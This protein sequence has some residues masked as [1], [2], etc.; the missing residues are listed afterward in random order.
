MTKRQGRPASIARQGTL[1]LL[2]LLLT[3]PA[4]GRVVAQAAQTTD[5]PAPGTTQSSPRPQ[6]PATPATEAAPA[7]A[8]TTTAGAQ[9]TTPPPAAPAPQPQIAPPQG[10]AIAPSEKDTGVPASRPAGAVIAPGKQR[11]RRSILIRVGLILG[12]A[13]AIGT[14]IGLSAASSSHP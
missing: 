6:P 9:Q 10:T 11:R 2:A 12:A 7:P 5:S 4:A 8:V 1:T 3:G 14:V 13:A